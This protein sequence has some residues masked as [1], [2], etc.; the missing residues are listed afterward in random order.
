MYGYWNSARKKKEG[1]KKL[2]KTKDSQSEQKK[3]QRKATENEGYHEEP[4]SRS[5]WQGFLIGNPPKSA[6]KPLNRW[7]QQPA[8][9]RDSKSHI[10]HSFRYIYI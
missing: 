7:Q 4:P 6:S 3:R 9:K 1:R 2:E 10:L 5:E 8:N